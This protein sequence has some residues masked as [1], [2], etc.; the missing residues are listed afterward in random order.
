[1]HATVKLAVSLAVALSGA[2]FAGGA[3]DIITK[4]K[5]SNCHTSKTTPKG[6]SWASVA[7]KYKGQPDAEAKLVQMLKNGG[8]TPDGDDHK[9]IAG[10]D[11][12]LKGVVA[13]VLSS[14]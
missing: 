5:C 11:A 12:D 4:E 9:K 13:I 14:K 3:E 7:A 10:S 1:M 6:P 2:A 8:P